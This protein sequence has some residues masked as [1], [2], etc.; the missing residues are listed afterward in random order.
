MGMVN[1][2][3]WGYLTNI[4]FAKLNVLGLLVIC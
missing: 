2:M 4:S 3:C 1:F